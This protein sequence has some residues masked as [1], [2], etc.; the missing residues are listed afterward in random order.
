MCEHL[1]DGPAEPND[2]KLPP[3]G[4]SASSRS[5]DARSLRGCPGDRNRGAQVGVWRRPKS[6]QCYVAGGL[7]EYLS[8]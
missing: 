2:T 6:W 1:S 8:V 5:A 3:A 7:G 4:R